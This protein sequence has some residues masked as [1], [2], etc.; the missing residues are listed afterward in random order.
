MGSEFG[1]EKT[2]SSESKPAA[3]SGAKADEEKENGKD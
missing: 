2:S 3:E 1:D